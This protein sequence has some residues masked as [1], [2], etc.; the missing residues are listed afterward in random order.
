[1]EYELMVIIITTAINAMRETKPVLYAVED[2][3]VPLLGQ[4][5]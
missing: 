2:Q 1:M 3:R 4:T 5:I